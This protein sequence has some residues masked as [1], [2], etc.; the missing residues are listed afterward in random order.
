MKNYWLDK[1]IYRDSLSGE[2]KFKGKFQEPTINKSN[3]HCYPLNILSNLLFKLKSKKGY[4]EK[5]LA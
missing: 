5:L 3:S 4:D 2:L 1:K